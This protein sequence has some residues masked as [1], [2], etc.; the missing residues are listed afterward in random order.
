MTRTSRMG[1]PMP[2][3]MAAWKTFRRESDEN[4]ATAKYLVSRPSWPKGRSL[5]ICDLGCADGQLVGKVLRRPEMKTRVVEIRLVEPDKE[6]LETAAS[7]LEKNRKVKKVTR[8]PFRVEKVW[9]HEAQGSDVILAVHLAYLLTEQALRTLV[10]DRPPASTLFVIL[11]APGSVFTELWAITAKKY[12]GRVVRAHKFLQKISGVKGDSAR[13]R[14][15]ARLPRN[16][17]F[18]HDYRGWLLSI[19][20]YTNMLKAS[21]IRKWEKQVCRVLNEHTDESEKFIECQ[22]VCYEFPALKAP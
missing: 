10:M 17:L 4:D 2:E 1:W 20:C 22:S 13:N 14:I 19:L 15:E 7:H 8:V 21:N 16:L 5:T 9:P 11:D 18:D 6:A 12:Y 3:Y